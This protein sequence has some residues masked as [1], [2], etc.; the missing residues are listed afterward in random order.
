MI[1][2]S[3][4]LGVVIVVFAGWVTVHVMILAGLLHRRQ[5]TRSLVAFVV[6]VLAPYWGSKDGMSTRAAAW[7]GLFAVYLVARVVA[8]M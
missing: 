1:G 7:I 6:P 4:K 3:V 8:A 5:W 2:E